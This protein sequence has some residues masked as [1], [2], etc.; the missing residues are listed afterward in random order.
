MSAEMCESAQ[1]ARDAC[2]EYFNGAGKGTGDEVENGLKAKRVSWMTMDPEFGVELA[3][4]EY[5]SGEGSERRLLVKI[6]AELPAP[7]RAI[8]E[9][10]A[11]H[12]INK[13]SATAEFKLA[14]RTAQAKH[15][16]IVKVLGKLTHDTAPDLTVCL[17]DK[18]LRT[19]VAKLQYFVRVP[20]AAASGADSGEVLF[21]LDALK[22]LHEQAKA[23]DAEGTLAKED[24]VKLLTYT[25]LLP[26]EL[27][28]S[29]AALNAKVE[30][31][32]VAETTGK[33]QKK[34]KKSAAATAAED[35]AAQEAMKM[36]S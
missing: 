19:F 34:S 5:L 18:Q 2:E 33:K 21:G 17:G 12:A 22:A 4:M 6:H 29:A 11:F 20:S 1:V 30:E 24:V 14:S 31:K 13:M 27:V 10:G 9:T 28:A 23:K 26:P 15:E 16:A 25:H 36:F 32:G 8:T 7:R 3:V 35:L